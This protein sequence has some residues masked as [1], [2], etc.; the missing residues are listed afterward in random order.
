MTEKFQFEK[1]LEDLEKIVVNVASVAA[2]LPVPC[3]GAY[4]ASKSALGMFSDTLRIELLSAG[5]QVLDVKPG[6]IDTGFSRR[7]LGCRKPPETLGGSAS[8]SVFASKV[9]GA[10]MKRKR[11]L[12]YP[13]WYRILIVFAWCFKRFYEAGSIKAWKI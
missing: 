9:F 2:L 6:R 12:M 13:S 1:A 7:S 5:V 4:C 11:K 10:C 3:M 8:A